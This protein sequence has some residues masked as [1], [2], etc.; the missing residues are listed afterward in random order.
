MGLRVRLAGAGAAGILLLSA[1]SSPAPP[2][3]AVVLPGL[4]AAGQA[5]AAAQANDDSGGGNP[6]GSAA[7]G[8][9]SF[10][11]SCLSVGSAY[12]S[13]MLALL[14]AI[15]GGQSGTYNADQVASALSGLG[16]NIPD[17][18]KPDFAAVSAATKAAAGKSLEEAGQILD[19]PAVKKATDDIDTWVTKNCGG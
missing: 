9:G 16:G 15:T 8:I 6:A 17:E 5:A 7:G 13:I 11:P 1:C 14:P 4:G 3:G 2:G 18:L 12:A 10:N 19:D